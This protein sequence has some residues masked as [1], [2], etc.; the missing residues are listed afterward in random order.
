MPYV[1]G[2]SDKYMNWWITVLTD[3]MSMGPND[4]I[5]GRD[6]RLTQQAWMIMHKYVCTEI[7]VVWDN[8]RHFR[9]TKLANLLLMVFYEYATTGRIEVIAQ[10]EA[11]ANR[12]NAVMNLWP[13]QR[14]GDNNRRN[15]PFALRQSTPYPSYK[16]SHDGRFKENY[17]YGTPGPWNMDG[18]KAKGYKHVPSKRYRCQNCGETGFSAAQCPCKDQMT[19]A[20]IEEEGRKAKR[21]NGRT[22]P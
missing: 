16:R 2:S 15:E 19:P 8:K 5:T 14:L 22:G 1:L 20:L 18:L 12:A 17:Q 9:W 11:K 6:L 10:P 4:P 7:D 21:G 3:I 13:T